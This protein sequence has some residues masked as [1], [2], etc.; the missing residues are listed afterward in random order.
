[1]SND[2]LNIIITAII[3]PTLAALVPLLISF[4]NQKTAELNQ[5]I[6][7]EK[8]NRYIDIA[9]DA[10]S[11]A[12][13][14]VFQTYV[15]TL[16]KQGKWNDATAEIAFTEARNKAIAIMGQAAKEALAQAYGDVNL[17]IDNKIEMHV[18]LNK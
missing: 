5:K 15:D 8:L 3:V 9:E 18:Q 14:S 11:T 10:V 2:T 13:T 1:M 12:V 7:N 16:K 4:L 6:G 17:W